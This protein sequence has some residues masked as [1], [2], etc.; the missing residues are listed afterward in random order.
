M[1]A[2]Q[3]KVAYQSTKYVPTFYAEPPFAIYKA[4]SNLSPKGLVLQRNPLPKHPKHLLAS[5]TA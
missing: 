3:G 2:L 1:K 4:R 5:F